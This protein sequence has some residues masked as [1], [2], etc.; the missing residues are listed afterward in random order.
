MLNELVIFKNNIY[1]MVMSLNVDYVGEI[2][3]SDNFS[4]KEGDAVKRKKIY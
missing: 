3:F 4:I 2:I 1:W